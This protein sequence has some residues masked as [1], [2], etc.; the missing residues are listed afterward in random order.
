MKIHYTCTFMT[1]L[2]VVF[3]CQSSANH[4]LLSIHWILAYFTSGNR[5]DVIFKTKKQNNSNSSILP[6]LKATKF[7]PEIHKWNIA[8]WAECNGLHNVGIIPVVN[9]SC[10]DECELI[11][12]RVVP[13][14]HVVVK[15]APLT[16]GM[17]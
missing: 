15:L 1:P 14:K 17:Q 2:S 4:F 6:V 10:V 16:T 9:L 3:S 11:L 13:G 5:F 12:V 8:E 7:P